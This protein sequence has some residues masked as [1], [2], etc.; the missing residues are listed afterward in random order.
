M[1]QRTLRYSYSLRGLTTVCF[2]MHPLFVLPQTSYVH[3][4][5]KCVC[6][7]YRL[8]L[9]CGLFI[10]VDS[11]AVHAERIHQSLD[12]GVKIDRLG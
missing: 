9:I 3:F 2:V 10:P 4:H 12:R 6:T 1:M 8:L 5:C 11:R 7:P